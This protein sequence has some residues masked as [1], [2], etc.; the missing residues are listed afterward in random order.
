MYDCP[1]NMYLTEM[2]DLTGDA[3]LNPVP[4]VYDNGLHNRNV[5]QITSISIHH[6]A[7][8]RP[9]DYDS[10]ARYKEE[11][12][13]HYDRLGPGLQYHY[14]IDNVGQIFK[15]RPLD[16]WLYCVGS[17]ENVTTLAICLDGNF[18]V[19]QPT[20]EQ[21]ESLY[22]LLEELCENHPEFP[23]TWPDVRPHADFSATA[24]C[25]LN[26][27]NRIYA[28][29]SKNTAADHLLNQ[30]VYDWPEYQTGAAPVPT[31]PSAPDPTP[32]LVVVIPVTPPV[33]DQ[34]HEPPTT[35][36]APASP[37]A[38]TPPTLPVPPSTPE[39][40]N[41]SPSLPS[42]PLSGF[43]LLVARIKAFIKSFFGSK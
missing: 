8:V 27:R 1:M 18:E 17:V 4:A 29:T 43:D 3:Y 33:V 40:P 11:A 24:C 20:R 31:P 5:S 12:A 41:Q 7:M 14:K 28:I 16:V 38:N 21:L 26:L 13:G 42:T 22:Q 35:S 6:D 32:P 23:A 10:V 30:G 37:P 25:G 34:S 36:P 19:Q 15:I 9:H 39:T 2:I